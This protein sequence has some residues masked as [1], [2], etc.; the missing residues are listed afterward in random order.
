MVAS[1]HGRQ[2][3]IAM[4]FPVTGADGTYRVPSIPEG[5]YLVSVMS[6]NAGRG[7]RVRAGEATTVDV[8]ASP[9]ATTGD[10]AAQPAP[11]PAPQPRGPI[12]SP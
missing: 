8:D 6:T 3:G 4:Y 1:N 5:N 11:A 7:V 2:D 9:P 10:G 12:A